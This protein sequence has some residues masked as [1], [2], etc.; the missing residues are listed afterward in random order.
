MK[1]VKYDA[2]RSSCAPNGIPLLIRRSSYWCFQFDKQILKLL[3]LTLRNIK[4]TKNSLL[5]QR[6]PIHCDTY[7]HV[8]PVPDDDELKFNDAST[9]G[10]ILR[11]EGYTAL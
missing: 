7:P 4:K 8:L 1:K 2:A 11:L 6:Q 9:H 3:C 10:V 5:I